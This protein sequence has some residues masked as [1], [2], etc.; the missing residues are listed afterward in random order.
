[1]NHQVVEQKRPAVHWSDL[2]GLARL[3]WAGRER[4][5]N[6]PDK[7]GCLRQQRDEIRVLALGSGVIEMVSVEDF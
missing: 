2:D 6:Y 5:D 7:V 3:V 1:M 4:V